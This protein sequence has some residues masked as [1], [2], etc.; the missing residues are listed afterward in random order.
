MCCWRVE[1]LLPEDVSSSQRLSLEW[2]TGRACTVHPLH[3][4]L[5]LVFGFLGPWQKN[6]G[7]VPAS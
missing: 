5:P 2:A 6:A 1:D 3:D 7:G 4:I